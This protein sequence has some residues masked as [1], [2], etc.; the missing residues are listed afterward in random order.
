MD[1]V[2]LV[3]VFN[4]H[5]QSESPVACATTKMAPG[6]SRQIFHIRYC[7]SLWECVCETICTI[8][9]VSECLWFLRLGALFHNQRASCCIRYPYGLWVLLSRFKFVASLSMAI[10]KLFLKEEAESQLLRWPLKRFGVAFDNFWQSVPVRRHVP[11]VG[12]SLSWYTGMYI[13]AMLLNISKLVVRLNLSSVDL[14]HSFQPESQMNSHTGFSITRSL[15]FLEI[16]VSIS[17]SIVV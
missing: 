8:S 1:G 16:I 14:H 5:W 15:S 7:T 3:S 4:D 13:I 10:E 12:L 6:W 2:I 9:V 11:F 17:S